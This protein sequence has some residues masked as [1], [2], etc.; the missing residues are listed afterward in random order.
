MRPLLLLHVCSTAA[1]RNAA[2]V[3]ARSKTPTTIA[4]C[5]LNEAVVPPAATFSVPSEI[6]VPVVATAS[7]ETRNDR[8]IAN[9]ALQA[10]AFD[11]YINMRVDVPAPSADN[12]SGAPSLGVSHDSVPLV[13]VCYD[14]YLSSS[15]NP[16]LLRCTCAFTYCSL[17]PCFHR[18]L[19]LAN[20]KLN[21]KLS[22]KSYLLTLCLVL[23]IILRIALLQRL[24]KGLQEGQMIY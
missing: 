16:F 8:V 7:S 11:A 6:E 19:K 18:K 13:S 23:L 1:Q 15:C 2:S 12:I 14:S 20:Q 22:P 10:D 9:S 3:G 4:F 24:R 17:H 21:R 5:A